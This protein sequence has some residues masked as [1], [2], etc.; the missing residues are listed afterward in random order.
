M[1]TGEWKEIMKS[2]SFFTVTFCLSVGALI[3]AP[4]DNDATRVPVLLELFTSEGCSSCPPA[5]RLLEILDQKQPV[6]GA[7]LIVLS[8]HVDYWD[9][10][11]WKD[12][13][14]SSQYTSRQQDYTNKYNFDGVYT[15]Q[16]VV[17]GR[18]GCVGSDGREASSAIQKAIRE[19]KI[20]IEIS[21]VSRDGNQVRA[22][23][24]LPAD[25]SFKGGH[26]ILFVAIADNRAESRV[27]RGENAG[28]SLTH[29]AV[30]RVFKQV[31]T[32]E[33]ESASAKDVSL[34]VQPGANGSRLVAFIQDPKSGHV[35][36]VAVQKL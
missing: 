8:E 35:L 15:P 23:I 12:P 19:R 28:R 10:L 21:N 29:V 27:A 25:Q 14:S 26:A 17:D 18:F 2:L 11:G 1:R 6:A 24:E 32:I 36:G 20:P 22:H 16:L 9:R 13:F 30:T 3:C 7:D 34:S 33:L 5:D 31:G 4:A